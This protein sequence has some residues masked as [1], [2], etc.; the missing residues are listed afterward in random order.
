[1]DDLTRILGV[2]EQVGIDDPMRGDRVALTL[3]PIAN[4][5]VAIPAG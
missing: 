1:L 4:R 3:A 2:A 5:V